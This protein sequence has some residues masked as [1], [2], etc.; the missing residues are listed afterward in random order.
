M[1]SEAWRDPRW[2]FEPSKARKSALDEPQFMER[3]SSAVRYGCATHFRGSSRDDES[4]LGRNA[5][6]TAHGADRNRPHYRRR[7]AAD[8]RW[9]DLLSDRRHR[10]AGVG[11][12]PVQGTAARRVDLRR[13]VRPERHL[14]LRGVAR[15]RL[16]DGAVAGRAAGAADR[17]APGDADADP[18]PTIAGS[19]PAAESRSASS[20]SP[21]AS[22]SWAR[23]AAPR[24]PRCPRKARP[25]WPIPR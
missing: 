2:R 8:P 15:Q 14:G 10:A 5:S 6:C 7:L 3:A 21:R 12:V 25:E 16:G 1:T 11:L 4:R 17:R 19:S 9:I 18:A 24:S 22:R 13:P 23:P 20:S